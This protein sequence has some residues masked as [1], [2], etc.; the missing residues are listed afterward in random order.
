MELFLLLATL[1]LSVAM[2]GLSLQLPQLAADPGGPGLFPL[3][4]AGITGIACV[5]LI[6]QR[7][8][9]ATRPASSFNF[10]GTVQSL[11]ARARQ[12]SRQLGTIVLVLAY[13]LGIDWI[14]FVAA[15]LL[16]SFLVL[17]TS[18]KRFVIAITASVLITAGIYVAYAKVLGAVLPEGWLIY[19]YF[20]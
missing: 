10:R 17:V 12:N 1:A 18:G 14:G 13:P 19:Q 8:L 2:G 7:I 6:G 9:F 5:L 11:I 16:F 3:A 15:T 4:A 20:Y